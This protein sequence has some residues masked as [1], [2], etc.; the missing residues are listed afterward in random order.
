MDAKERAFQKRIWET[1]YADIKDRSDK[2][3]A[4]LAGNKCPSCGWFLSSKADKCI[5]C[6]WER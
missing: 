5:K 2:E 1:Q 6:G 4:A 3:E